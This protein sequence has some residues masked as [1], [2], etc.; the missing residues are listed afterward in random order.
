MKLSNSPKRYNNYK[1]DFPANT[2][3]I[4]ESG[5][6]R[7]GIDIE[8]I[9]IEDLSKHNFH[10]GIAKINGLSIIANGKGI[11]KE[12]AMASAYGELVERFSARFYFRF[13]F[14]KNII[15][16]VSL[17]WANIYKN[18]RFYFN[19]EDLR[20]Y[21][22]ALSRE[23]RY[24]I[25]VTDFLRRYCLDEEKTHI[26]LEKDF[27]YHWVDAYS[28]IDRAYLKVPVK[29][30]DVISGSNGLASGNT[31]E[32]A[33]V[34][35]T[36]EIF[37]RY[38][39]KYVIKTKKEIPTVDINSIKNEKILKMISFFNSLNID[40]IIKD[41]SLNNRFPVI[42]VLF[43]NENLLNES[44]HIKRD[45][46]YRRLR[47]ASHFNLEEALIRCFMEELQGYTLNEYI[48]HSKLDIIWKH[49]VVKMGKHY[50]KKIDTYKY[51]L[52]RYDYFGDL[53]YLEKKPSACHFNELINIKT[54]DFLRDIELIERICKREQWDLLILNLTHPVINFPVVRI[55]VPSISDVLDYYFEE[56]RISDLLDDE[57][58]FNKI[59]I[60]GI[61]RFVKNKSWL[62]DIKEIR[63]FIGC[64]E[65]HLTN[66]PHV[67]YIH[68]SNYGL[69][70][71]FLFEALT[72]ASLA[73]RNYRSAENYIML[74]KDLA[75]ERR[76]YDLAKT[77]TRA[78]YFNEFNFDYPFF[79]YC[80][81]DNCKSSIRKI[82]E[83]L[84]SFLQ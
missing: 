82:D 18:N 56:S 49:W 19:Y 2:I 46:Y 15:D 74:I 3:K 39:L 66:Y 40:I 24:K 68:L 78:V 73:I 71:V 17:E 4:I 63:G 25:S 53:S 48:D 36:C 23:I 7:L 54:D 72:L 59:Y 69:K 50:S 31:L 27:S 16:D 29:F 12:L 57:K 28:L 11:N 32:E 9:P 10:T 55:I 64:I 42:R 84:K 6:K 79:S 52:T 81:C 44:N 67:Y 21:E 13:S 37:E 76:S 41:F 1:A 30:I 22:C 47:V 5:F 8:Y 83:L 35:A 43:I 75:G 14:F 70:N 61:Y 45:L 33:I 38:C 77:L 20:G 62:K 51:L 34:Q 65:T 58:L 26:L 80:S 60:D